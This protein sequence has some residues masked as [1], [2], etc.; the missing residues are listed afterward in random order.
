M[1]RVEGAKSTN[2]AKLEM[3]RKEAGKGRDSYGSREAS[4]GMGFY[5][6]ILDYKQVVEGLDR[7]TCLLNIEGLDRKT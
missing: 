6:C 4:S 1:N 3:V 7:I 2:Q 5:I